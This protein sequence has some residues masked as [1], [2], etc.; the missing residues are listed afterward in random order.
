MS[1]ETLVIRQNSE[2]ISIQK[3]TMFHSLYNIDSQELH[4]A[5]IFHEEHSMIKKREFNMS[6]VV[7]IVMLALNLTVLVIELCLFPL[8][9]F[10]VYFTN[11]GLLITIVSLSLSIKCASDTQLY[12]KISLMGWHHLIFELALIMELIITVVYWSLIHK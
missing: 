10:P 11:W 2:T 6:Q 5:T 3:R 12:T 7:R 9:S 4:Q 1:T 8:T